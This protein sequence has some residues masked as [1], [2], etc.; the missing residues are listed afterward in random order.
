MYNNEEE[1]KENN[2]SAAR[3]EFYKTKELKMKNLMN[4]VKIVNQNDDHT[5]QETQEE[6]KERGDMLR[7]SMPSYGQ[8]NP[9][10]DLMEIS[11]TIASRGSSPP[12]ATDVRKSGALLQSNDP[13][14]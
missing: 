7:I 11:Q 8:I 10:I 1:R 4:Q 12:T 3:D 9:I 14:Q 2:L 13:K 5:G 6:I